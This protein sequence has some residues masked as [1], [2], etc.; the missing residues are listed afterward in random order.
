MGGLAWN[1]ERRAGAQAGVAGQAWGPG[2][3]HSLVPALPL[4]FL[5]SWGPDDDGKTV[6]G[7]HQLGKV[8]DLQEAW[9]R[10]RHTLPSVA[11]DTAGHS[12]THPSAG[13][14]RAI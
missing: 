12:L 11:E 13:P 4:M 7:P 9:R 8:P 6:D 5:H 10:P 2:R 3:G 1:L 14:G